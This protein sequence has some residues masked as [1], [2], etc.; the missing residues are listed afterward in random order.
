LDSKCYYEFGFDS[1]Q[2]IS[3]LTTQKLKFSPI[4]AI[5]ALEGWGRRKIAPHILNP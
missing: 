4:N 3:N 1:V 2:Y 5:K